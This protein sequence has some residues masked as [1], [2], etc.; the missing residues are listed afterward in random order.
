MKNHEKLLAEAVR[1]EYEEK[2][3][4][5]YIVFKVLDDKFKHDIKTE[6]TKDIEYKLINRSLVSTEE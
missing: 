4:N 2:S 5:L 3:G 1:I 6:W